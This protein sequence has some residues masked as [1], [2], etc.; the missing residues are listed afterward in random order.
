MRIYVRTDTFQLADVME[1]FIGVCLEKYKLD[2]V[3]YVT[4][5][6][7]AWDGMLKVTGVEIELLTD[8]DMYLF[9]EEGIRGGVSSAMK[10]YLKGNN[11]YMKD[12]DPEKPSVFI[13]YQDK[14]GL[15]TSVLRRP[16]PV[17]GFR[18]LTEVEINEMMEGHYYRKLDR[19]R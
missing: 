12:Y 3:H 5:A 11:K 18:W 1:N 16:F 17:G 8:S 13:T 7:L 19:A 15:Y 6:A 10:R 9:F 14:N 4:A 2:P